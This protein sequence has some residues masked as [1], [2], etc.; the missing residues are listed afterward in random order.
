[1]YTPFGVMY[2]SPYSLTIFFPSLDRYGAS[3]PKQIHKLWKIIHCKSTHN[4]PY[5][6]FPIA[7]CTK[8]EST[9]GHTSI[10]NQEKDTLG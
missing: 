5:T 4:P 8:H 1:M 3:S 10:S 7:F 2:Q 6:Y 9:E